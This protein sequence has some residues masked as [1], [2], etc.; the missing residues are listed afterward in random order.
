VPARPRVALISTH[1]Y[2]RAASPLTPA[3][4]QA[5]LAGIHSDPTG[6]TLAQLQK[7]IREPTADTQPF[8]D[9]IKRGELVLPRCNSCGRLHHCPRPYCA[10]CSSRDLTWVRCSGKGKIHSY[11]IEH[12]QH[13]LGASLHS[14]PVEIIAVVEINGGA[15]ILAGLTGITPDSVRLDMPVEIVFEDLDDGPTMFKFKPA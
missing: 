11:L 15:R 5:R 14:S 4:G 12:R 13:G 10:D 7:P 8:W 6:S 1:R 2:S 9:G 3:V